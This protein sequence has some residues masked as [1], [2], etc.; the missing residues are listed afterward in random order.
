M[1]YTL[2]ILAMSALGMM[3]PAAQAA[4]TVTI[5]KSATSSLP[6]IWQKVPAAQRLQMVRAAELDATRILAERIMGISLDGESTVKDLAA[7]NETIRGQLAVA[8]KGVKTTSGPTYHEDGRVEVVRA[9]KIKSL[10]ETISTKSTTGKTK[11]TLST[12]ST[13]IDAL[14]NA[15]IPGSDGH[16][17]VR[18]K[19]AAEMDVYR[20]LAER[21][22]GIQLSS[23]TT[24]K[25]FVME[26]D[27]LKASFSNT[28]KSAEITSI[29]Y[30]DE[31]CAAVTATLKVGPL[32]RVI[33]KKVAASGKV[34]NS[35]EVKTQTVLEE[36][37]NGAPVAAS[38][39]AP[40]TAP[41]AVEVDAMIESVLASGI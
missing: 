30:D 11:T 32:V 5:K 34:L 6:A 8:I 37:G 36:T 40:A 23:D 19:R 27:E 18:A 33:V 24:V 3:I 2:L 7:L 14:G 22:C 38:S 15:A 9:V 39:A 13:E 16:Q 25:D 28:V 17:R 29:T 10:I 12:V 31:N 35:S 41:T 26:S 1:K 4:P 21:L 20:R